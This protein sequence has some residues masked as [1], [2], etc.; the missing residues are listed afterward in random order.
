MN[1]FHGNKD[2]FRRPIPI[3]GADFPAGVAHA[4]INGGGQSP[5]EGQPQQS[6][7]DIQ[8]AEGS[9]DRPQW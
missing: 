9:H 6:R 2:R 4:E 8:V 5:Q 1:D 7:P 3:V